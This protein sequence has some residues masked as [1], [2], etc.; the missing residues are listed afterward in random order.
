MKFSILTLPEARAYSDA[1]LMSYDD[2]LLLSRKWEQGALPRSSCVR[3]IS[4]LM[5]DKYG[6]YAKFTAPNYHS[7]NALLRHNKFVVTIFT[8]DNVDPITYSV[9]EYNTL[10]T[11][12]ASLHKFRKE[13]GKGMVEV[14]KYIGD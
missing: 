9:T 13:G 4:K 1:K 5:K 12:L 10:F 8:G 3:I 7:Y 2:Y 11:I 6:F 14:G